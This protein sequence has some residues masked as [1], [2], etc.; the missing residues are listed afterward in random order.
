MARSPCES[1]W[2]IMKR[3]TIE[4]ELKKIRF[5]GGGE[6]ESGWNGKMQVNRKNKR[7]KN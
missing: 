1:F 3:E 7:K 2:I 6:K 4:K 5:V